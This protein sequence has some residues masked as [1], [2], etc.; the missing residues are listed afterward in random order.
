MT[1]IIHSK[2][3]SILLRGNLLKEWC[4]DGQKKKQDERVVSVKFK[5]TVLTSTYQPVDM[6]TNEAEI[7][8][9][10]GVLKQHKELVGRMTSYSEEG[11]LMLMWEE[12]RK[13]RGS[14]VFWYKR[15]Q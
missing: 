9:A 14:R 13:E 8:E 12:G 10:K 4:E 15:K 11:I 3:A 2:R 5:K 1:V 7:E 6:G